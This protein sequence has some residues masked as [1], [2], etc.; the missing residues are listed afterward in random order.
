MR[1]YPQTRAFTIV[2]LL[3]VVSIIALLVGILLPAIGKARDNAQLTRSQANLRNLGAAA[4]TYAA[5]YGD[6]QFSLIDDNFGRYGSDVTEASQNFPGGHPISV[7]GWGYG[8]QW[9]Y[10]TS[11]VAAN[12]TRMPIDFSTKFGAFRMLNMRAF[13]TFVNGRFYD[14]VFYAPKDT[15]AVSTVLKYQELPHEFA[16]PED[17]GLPASTPIP[18][19]SYCFS[20][21]AMYNPAVFSRQA[22]GTYF[23]DP[24]AFDAG[25]RSPSMSQATYSNLKTHI[26]EHHWL[27]GRR[28]ECNPAFTNGTY[29]GCEPYYFNHSRDSKP[30]CLFYDGHIDIIGYQTAEAH[31]YRVYQQNGQTIGL[32]NNRVQGNGYNLTSPYP[33]P[34]DP[35]M[36]TGGY[37]HEQSY[38]WA[39]SSFHILTT[40][41]IKGRDILAN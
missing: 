14:E 23:K 40:D 9:W 39:V 33:T 37:W 13:N 11:S 17:L 26:I 2:E 36:S 31:N 5:E 15:A 3:V 24:F 22:D 4:Q 25:F 29:D 1:R 32:W 30:V 34:G 35:L 7:L 18:W 27:Q 20:P 41:G 10:W 16:P 8:G 28:K 38:D 12:R 21:A 6:R 19:S